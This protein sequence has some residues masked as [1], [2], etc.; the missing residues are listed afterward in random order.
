[1]D[2]SVIIPAYDEERRIERGLAGVLGYLADRHLDA[3]V[4]VVDDGSR[5]RTAAV[6]EGIAA[7]DPRVRLLRHTE[8]RGKGAAVR[9]GV[10]AAEGRLILFTDTDQST[11]MHCI[12]R[13]IEVLDAGFDLA[14]ASREI[15]G[16]RRLIPQP[17]HRRAMGHLFVVLRSLLVL[18]GFIDT[19][20]GFKLFRREVAK[21]VFARTRIDGFAFDVEVLAVALHRGFRVSEVPVEWVDDPDSRVSAVSD[22][23]RAIRDLLRSRRHL[24]RG[25]YGKDG[26]AA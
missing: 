23:L 19:Q 18:P 15:V 24:R 4:L 2:L 10:L 21:D 20:C 11:P 7:R 17:F 9:T 1:M 14:I 16:A 8:N 22:S 5:D 6:V 25:T 13:L 12:E 3:E 26:P